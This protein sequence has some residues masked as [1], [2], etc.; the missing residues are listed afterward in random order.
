MVA[1]FLTA[2]HYRWQPF[3]PQNDLG[4]RLSSAWKESQWCTYCTMHN[5]LVSNIGYWRWKYPPLPTSNQ[6]HFI[7]PASSKNDWHLWALDGGKLHSHFF[8]SAPP[9]F[10]RFL[11]A[12]AAFFPSPATDRKNICQSEWQKIFERARIYLITFTTN[13]P[14]YVGI[15][16]DRVF[17]LWS[18]LDKI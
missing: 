8:A 17:C 10:C 13:L 16:N 12:A 18:V 2:K 9:D 4:G 1:Y 7:C 15:H 14:L 6:P 3:Y 5:P 11:S